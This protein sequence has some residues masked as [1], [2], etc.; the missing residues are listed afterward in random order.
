MSDR[1]IRANS[2][3]SSRRPE[4]LRP[5]AEAT[6]GTVRRIGGGRQRAI[7]LP[8]LVAMHD[9]PVYGGS[10]YAAIKRTGASEV[11]G[12][13]VAPLAIGFLGLL[14]LCGSVTASLAHRGAGFG[15]QVA[16]PRFGRGYAA[17]M[18]RP[19]TSAN[20]PSTNSQ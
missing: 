3:R 10:D 20:A 16:P 8:R 6:G 14:A 17:F 5:L 19:P 4:K 18:T 2:R 7:T 11:T 1:K 12:V 15:A 9:S 13:G